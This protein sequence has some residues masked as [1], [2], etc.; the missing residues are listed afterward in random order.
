MEVK[1]VA[2]I[3]DW[4]EM[5]PLIVHLEVFAPRFDLLI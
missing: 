4:M 5:L 3:S 1:A 2:K